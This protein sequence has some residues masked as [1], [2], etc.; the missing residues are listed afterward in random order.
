MTKSTLEPPA[1]FAQRL[2]DQ[3]IKAGADAA[4]AVVFSSHSRSV[5]IRDG[6]REGIDSSESCEAGLRVF[7]GKAQAVVSTSKIDPDE[8]SKLAVQVV[9]MAQA[10]PEDP[11]AGLAAAEQLATEITDLDLAD[12]TTLTTDQLLELALQAEGA[13][14]SVAGVTA[15]AGT[16]ASASRRTIGLATSN[17]FCGQYDRT[18]YSVSSSFIAGSGTKMARD[19]EYD[20][21]LHFKDLAAAQSIGRAAA[22]RAV[23]RE[24][25]RKVPSQAVPV[26][27]EQRL[28]GSLLNHLAGAINGAAVVRGTS[29][30]KD[31][32]GE[33]VFAEGVSIVDDGRQAR[34]HGS[35]P[36][37]AEGLPTQRRVV[38]DDGVLAS[39]LLDLS[40]ARQL[41]LAPTGN[42]SRGASN[43]PSPST[44]NF[45]MQPGQ[46]S[47]MALMSDIKAGFLVTEL[48]GMGVNGVTGD[49][50]RGASGFWI[51]DGE[52]SYPVS[53]ITIAGNLN[54][55]YLALTPASDLVIRGATNA[56]TCRIEEMT[57][58]GT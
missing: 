50:S 16:G 20:T 41:G 23:R 32:L 3:A 55:M 2:V 6:E 44:G 28:A 49:Y 54:D 36:F 5:S 7:A 14:R 4:D 27:F 42:A 40:S 46:L 57:I 22:E 38:V 17:G 26:V 35:K 58:A 33:R 11:F 34:G 15:A 53:E 47:P 31:R 24:N 18:G 13:G 9:A 37:D 52:I 12:E 8:A 25:P 48:I 21:S 43:T 51:E 56:P 1:S 45:N 19:Y 30:L 39:W 29:F 10:A